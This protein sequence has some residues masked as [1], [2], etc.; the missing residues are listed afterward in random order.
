MVRAPAPNRCNPPVPRIA[1][2]LCSTGEFHVQL[3][4]RVHDSPVLAGDSTYVLNF[5]APVSKLAEAAHSQHLPAWSAA[6][7]AIAAWTRAFILEDR[8]VLRDLG[9]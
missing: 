5:R 1:V 2:V 7:V 6:D 8:A 4:R 9:L 3:G